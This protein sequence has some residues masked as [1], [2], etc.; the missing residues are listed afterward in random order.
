[1]QPEP[2][3]ADLRVA[4]V[5]RRWPAAFDVFQR[6]GCPDMRS[7]F[8]A[9]MARIMRVRWAARVHRIPLADLLDE[10]NACAKRR[11]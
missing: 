4:D 1:M 2:V 8:F 9:V 5:L 11:D 3:T 7:G 6:R 10:L